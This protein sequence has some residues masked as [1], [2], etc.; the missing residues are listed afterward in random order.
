MPW[1]CRVQIIVFSIWRGN[2]NEGMGD[3]RGSLGGKN[4]Q[5]KEGIRSGAMDFEANL[6]DDVCEGVQVRFAASRNSN[7]TAK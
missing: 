5:D 1:N 2:W 7:L 6:G 4:E 3:G